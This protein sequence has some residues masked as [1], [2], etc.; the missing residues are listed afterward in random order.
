MPLIKGKSQKAFVHNL[1]TEMEHG[2]PQKQ[3][4]AIAYSMKRKAQHKAKGGDIKGVHEQANKMHPDKSDMGIMARHGYSEIAKS[5]SQDKLQELKEM[6]NPKLQGL[7]DGGPIID[8]EKAKQ[9]A[10]SFKGAVH[11]YA[12]GGECPSCG[13]SEGGFIGSY[14]SPNKSE[15]DR[16]DG[17]EL[18]S[19]Y[20]SH[21]GNDIKHNEMAHME[22]DKDLNQ[23]SVHPMDSDEDD[24]V[25]RIMKKRS[26]AYESEARYSEGGRVSN[27]THPFEADFEDPNEFDDLVLRDDLEFGYDGK[28]SGDELGNEQEDEDRKDIVSRIMASRRKKDRMPNPA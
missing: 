25:S 11:S 21:M 10:D 15:V 13:Y 16:E 9:V 8:P 3:S 22:D 28:N 20:E 23:H 7:A 18:A 24:M 14:Q 6:P 1:K 2:H 19:G 12:H 17:N 27:N 26:P 5:R 4:L